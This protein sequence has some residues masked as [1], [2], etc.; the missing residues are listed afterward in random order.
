VGEGRRVVA[1]TTR[2]CC[3][4]RKLYKTITPQPVDIS[5]SVSSV[6]RVKVLIVGTMAYFDV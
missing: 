3:S 5:L 4:L 6:R 2:V 1:E